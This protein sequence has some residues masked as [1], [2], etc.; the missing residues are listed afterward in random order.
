MKE[1]TKK[2][3]NIRKFSF[4][5]TPVLRGSV[6]PSSNNNPK[7]KKRKKIKEKEKS[8]ESIAENLFKFLCYNLLPFE[9]IKKS[10][11]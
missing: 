3:R 8:K 1:R 7:K 2:E 9:S 5:T 11:W 4:K 6:Y 10:F